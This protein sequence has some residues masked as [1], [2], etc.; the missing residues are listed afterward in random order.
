M[1]LGSLKIDIKSLKQGVQNGR[2]TVTVR[3]EKPRNFFESQ[4][5]SYC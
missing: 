5:K 1:D 3:F 2:I 4:S